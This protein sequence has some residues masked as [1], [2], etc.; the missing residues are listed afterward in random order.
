MLLKT[1]MEL[2]ASQ[3]NYLNAI[4]SGFDEMQL[5]YYEIKTQYTVP[6]NVVKFSE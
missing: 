1:A 6:R 5:I 2:R 3:R 4:T